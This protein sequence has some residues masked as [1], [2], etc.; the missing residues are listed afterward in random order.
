MLKHLE[1]LLK[2]GSTQELQ[3]AHA[4]IE[5]RLKELT[6]HKFLTPAEQEEQ[7]NLKRIKLRIKER[8]VK[9]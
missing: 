2:D 6:G 3:K 4:D 1:R 5:T 7:R 8:L 9:P